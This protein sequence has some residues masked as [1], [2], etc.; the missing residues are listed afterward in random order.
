MSESAEAPLSRPEVLEA[1]RMR[2]RELW[3][4]GHSLGEIARWLGVSRESVR[5]WKRS[6]EAGGEAALRRR[7]APGPEPK[8]DEAGAERVRAALLEGARAQ[9]FDSELW[10][11]ER[12]QQVV[13]RLTGV[14]LSIPS[15]WRLLT[16]RL[17]FT[18]QRPQRVAAE[19]DGAEVARWRAED[20]PRIKGGP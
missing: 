16:V 15:V 1:K 10:T 12:V 19:R 14:E 2:A 3:E 7:P 18:A 17:G 20:W 9:G 11:L 5:R 8:V 4:Q 13:A 6:W